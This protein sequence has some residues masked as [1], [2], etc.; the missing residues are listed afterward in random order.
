MKARAPFTFF[1]PRR[2]SAWPPRSDWRSPQQV[3]AV[4]LSMRLRRLLARI[5]ARALAF[6]HE[7]PRERRDI[8]VFLVGA[9]WGVM[10][11]I[12]MMAAWD[13]HP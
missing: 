1:M 9:G 3:T 8:L 13:I 4:P 5:R 10:C 11:A 12:G 2:R 6:I 7:D